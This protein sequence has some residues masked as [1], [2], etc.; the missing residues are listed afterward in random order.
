[1]PYYLLRYPIHS[2]DVINNSHDIM[3]PAA[4]KKHVRELLY[5]KQSVQVQASPLNWNRSPYKTGRKKKEN[6]GG[7]EKKKEK[8][9]HY[10]L[11]PNG[12]RDSICQIMQAELEWRGTSVLLTWKIVSDQQMTNYWQNN[13]IT[14]RGLFSQC[15]SFIFYRAGASKSHFD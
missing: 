1:M 2:N 3:A 11:W 15:W 5:F 4:F 9:E 10:I 12:T 13:R 7:W 6:W 14:L 8:C